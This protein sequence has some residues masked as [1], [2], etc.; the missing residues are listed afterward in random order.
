MFTDAIPSP[1][2]NLDVRASGPIVY[3]HNAKQSD[4][5]QPPNDTR[6]IVTEKKR[7]ALSSTVDEIREQLLKCQKEIPKCDLKALIFGELKLKEILDALQACLAYFT[8]EP[9]KK[10]KSCVTIA[11]AATASNF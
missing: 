1:D 6:S 8:K 4:T 3:A 10:M 5:A 9:L 2:N 11:K 7:K